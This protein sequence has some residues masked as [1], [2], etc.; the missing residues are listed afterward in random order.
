MNKM[1]HAIED[2]RRLLNRV[3]RRAAHDGVSAPFTAQKVENGRAPKYSVPESCTPLNV[4]S[5]T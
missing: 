3:R 4:P 1:T 5:K 2:E